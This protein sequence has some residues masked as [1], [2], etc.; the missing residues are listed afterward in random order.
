MQSRNWHLQHWH[1]CRSQR[2]AAFR[3]SG[4]PAECKK[5]VKEK[6]R[7]YKSD[8]ILWS[9]V[10]LQRNFLTQCLTL[11]LVVQPYVSHMSQSNLPQLYICK[12]IPENNEF[13]I[14]H[15]WF[16]SS[17]SLKRIRHEWI[18]WKFRVRGRRSLPPLPWGISNKVCLACTY[19]SRYNWN[20]FAGS[21]YSKHQ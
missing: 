17:V 7:A 19:F 16:I 1:F 9:W 18:A 6:N 4:R 14:P 3:G 2:S 10:S 8:G 20:L 15:Y 12:F 11:Q 5:N 21:S 13:P